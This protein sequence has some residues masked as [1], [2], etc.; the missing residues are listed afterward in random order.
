MG[1]NIIGMCQAALS[2]H[3]E[4]ISTMKDFWLFPTSLKH[5]FSLSNHH[6]L[7]LGF[8]RDASLKPI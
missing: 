7:L 4:A 8:Q 1:S 6:C 2:K 3:L 5:L